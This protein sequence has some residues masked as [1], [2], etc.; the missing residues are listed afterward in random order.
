MD[1]WDRALFEPKT[2][3]GGAFERGF[4][5]HAALPQQSS[6]HC[7]TAKIEAIAKA[8]DRP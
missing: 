4:I 8:P 2:A 7:D 3:P 6:G 1:H 5:P